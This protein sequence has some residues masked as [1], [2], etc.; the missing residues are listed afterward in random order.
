[1]YTMA[2]LPKGQI[3][4]E[5][6]AMPEPSEHS[7]SWAAH[8]GCT[9]TV[10]VATMDDAERLESERKNL[11]VWFPSV[12]VSRSHAA[13]PCTEKRNPGWHAST[14]DVRSPSIECQ[15]VAPC[16]RSKS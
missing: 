6:H 13:R 3:P 16:T 7:C 8:A 2:W 15:A 12:D 14:C 5:L 11:T 1:M 4:E 10:L 9:T